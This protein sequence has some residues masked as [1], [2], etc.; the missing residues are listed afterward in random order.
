MEDLLVRGSVQVSMLLYAVYLAW[1]AA[2]R[3]VA[4][5]G[6]LRWIWSAGCLVFLVHVAA[7]FH[8]H[9]D[10]SHQQA[11]QSTA[12]D[13]LET[14]GLEF[15]AGIY[16]SYTFAL[17]WCLDVAWMWI[18]PTL[19]SRRAPWLSVLLHGYMLAIAVNGAIVF[20]AGVTRW[21]GL[22]VLLLLA[23]LRARSGRSS[24]TTE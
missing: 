6:R 7:A 16:F 1:W 11:Y 13:T 3:T 20:A 18:W 4:S 22:L 2:T 12:A 19:H 24:V 23:V 14:V 5:C 8:F 17:V 15:G 21:S 9:H 10:W